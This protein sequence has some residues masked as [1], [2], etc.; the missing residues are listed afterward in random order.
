MLIRKVRDEKGLR[1]KDLGDGKASVTTIS[2][3]ERG[4]NQ[5]TTEMITYLLEKLGIHSLEELSDML[6]HERNYLS[7][8]QFKLQSIETLVKLQQYEKA[9]NN[10]EQL[11]LSDTHHYAPWFYYLNGRCLQGLHQWIQAEKLFSY[12]INLLEER[13]KEDNIESACYLETSYCEYIMNDVNSALLFTDQGIQAF[14]EDGDRQNVLHQLYLN[15]SVFYN[16]MNRMEGIIALDSLSSILHQVKDISIKL[17]YYWLRAE[18]ARKSGKLQESLQYAEEGLVLAEENNS[19]NMILEFW[20]CIG[21]TLASMGD[22]K[23]AENRLLLAIQFNPSLVEPRSIVSGNLRLGMLYLRQNLQD[24]AESFLNVARTMAT[25]LGDITK[26]L[27]ALLFL[28][29]IEIN[30]ENH[31]SAVQHYQQAQEL[32]SQ[33]NFKK[34]EHQAWSRLAN[35]WQNVNDNEFQKCASKVLE[36]Q[37]SAM[38]K[39]DYY[40]DEIA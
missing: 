39:G 18:Y 26:L 4:T 12:A 32:A 15:K 11:Q 30:K 9:L 17:K 19:F 5:H 1:L 37:E 3:I 40:Y 8:I 21:D 35:A 27:H 25:D 20:L 10:L 36:L 29:D 31:S 7:V 34:H 33:Y 2:N 38:W 23:E 14:I 13:P 22:F 24:K 28:G 16:K 6:E